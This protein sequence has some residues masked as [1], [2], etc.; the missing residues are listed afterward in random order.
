MDFLWIKNYMK[1]ETLCLREVLHFDPL[2]HKEYFY[3]VLMQNSPTNLKK[4]NEREIGIG[5][6][7]EAKQFQKEVIKRSLQ[8]KI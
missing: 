4:E 8:E 6:R 3:M 7:L 5:D 1:S 2:K